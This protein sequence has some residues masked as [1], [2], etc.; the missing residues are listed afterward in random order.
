MK[1]IYVYFLVCISIVGQTETKYS[2]ELMDFVKEVEKFKADLVNGELVFSYPEHF[3]DSLAA[4]LVFDYE[5]IMIRRKGEFYRFFGERKELDRTEDVKWKFK[6]TYSQFKNRIKKIFGET[7]IRMLQIPIALRG[8][9]ISE[10]RKLYK[11]DLPAYEFWYKVEIFE[12]LFGEELLQNNN[13]VDVFMVNTWNMPRLIVGKEYFLLVEFRRD[14]ETKEYTD[15][16]IAGLKDDNNGNYPLVEGKVTL[17]NDF[18][19]IGNNLDWNAFKKK[20]EDVYLS[21]LR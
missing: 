15:C 10:E 14:P 21:G 20:F 16:G 13:Y 12:I 18:P 2:K 17:R 7:Y 8:R 3:L 1:M 11:G 9:I 4:E 19:D 6:N 5:E